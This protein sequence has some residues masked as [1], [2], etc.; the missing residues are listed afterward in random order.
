MQEM[1]FE[2]IFNKLMNNAV[3]EK[4][5]KSWENIVILNLSQQKEEETI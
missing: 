2:N 3:F 5:W 1:I 4:L